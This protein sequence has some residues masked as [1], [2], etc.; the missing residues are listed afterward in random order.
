ML[1]GGNPFE[2]VVKA[3][4]CHLKFPIAVC[5]SQTCKCLLS[6]L[7][8]KN[9]EERMDMKQLMSHT[10][11]ANTEEDLNGMNLIHA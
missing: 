7:L 9:L 6:A 10:W 5:M 3:E 8:R 1:T 2:D 11:T 4:Q